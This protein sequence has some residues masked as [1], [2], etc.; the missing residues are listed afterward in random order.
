MS[1]RWL[2]AY[3]WHPN[4]DSNDLAD[5]QSNAAP[6]GDPVLSVQP[7]A[8]IDSNVSNETEDT[9]QVADNTLVANDQVNEDIDADEIGGTPNGAGGNVAASNDARENDIPNDSG[10]AIDYN[11]AVVDATDVNDRRDR[12]RSQ[13]VSSRR[14][15]SRRTSSSYVRA[16]PN[17][18]DRNQNIR[19]A[20]IRQRT[21]RFS[22]N[23]AACV[24]CDKPFV[25]SV[26]LSICARCQ[27]HLK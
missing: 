15:S 13:R 12:N 21:E 6:A 3:F 22:F 16:L 5:V 19:P 18:S 8:A 23:V 9:N 26:G 1:L 7:D 4:L 11:T 20:R 14:V 27:N 2:Y 10:S 25:S 17:A 24:M